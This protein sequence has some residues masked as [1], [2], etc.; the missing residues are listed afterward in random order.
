M[1]LPQGFE[2]VSEEEA[3]ELNKRAPAEADAEYVQALKAN[4]GKTIRLPRMPEKDWEE[5]RLKFTRAATSA[6]LVLSWREVQGK[7]VTT[8]RRKSDV[9][10]RS[11]EALVNIRKA[12]QERAQR[13]RDKK[14]KEDAAKAAVSSPNGSGPTPP[15]PTPPAP[16]RQPAQ[17]GRSR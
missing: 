8:V 10:P 1:P 3:K 15:A 14:A 5:T 6:E 2:I 9:K 17:A 7:H 13:Q 4:V 16:P 12:A 11:E